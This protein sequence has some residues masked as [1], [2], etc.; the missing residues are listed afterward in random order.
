MSS[1]LEGKAFV[2]KVPSK[3]LPLSASCD[4]SGPHFL[5]STPPQMAASCL[6]SVNLTSSPRSCANSFWGDVNICLPQWGPK[7][8]TK[9]GSTKV[10]LEEPMGLLDLLVKCGW[11]ITDGN[12]R[13]SQMAAPSQSPTPSWIGTSWSIPF[14]TIFPF[15]CILRSS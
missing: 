4:I 11:W 14:Q 10:Q 3:Q 6:R 9:D 13:D 5:L 8:Q 1:V 2:I 15:L 7:D 12:V